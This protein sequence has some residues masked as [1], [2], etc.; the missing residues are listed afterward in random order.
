MHQIRTYPDPVLRKKAQPVLEID[1]DLHQLV[2]EMV[3][4]MYNDDGIGLAANQ[5]GDLRRVIVLDAGDGFRAFINPEIINKND[6]EV[7][8]EEGCL[9]FPGIHINI[10]RPSEV[11]V[12]AMDLEGESI[13]ITVDGLLAKVFQH[14]IDHLNG[15]LIIDYASPLHRSLLKRKLEKIEKASTD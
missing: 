12:K 13:E 4:I 15:I 14:E 2:D 6:N 3:D 9:S 7:V 8:M 11:T 10:S 1:D 5:A